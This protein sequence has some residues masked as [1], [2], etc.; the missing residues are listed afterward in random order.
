MINKIVQTFSKLFSMFV[1]EH[2]FH[3]EILMQVN[4]LSI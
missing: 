3:N 1:N 4:Y 2:H